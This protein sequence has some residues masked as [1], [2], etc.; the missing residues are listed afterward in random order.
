MQAGGRQAVREEAGSEDE[1]PR[2]E[3]VGTRGMNTQRR[4][5]MCACRLHARRRL[6]HS[7]AAAAVPSSLSARS[8]A[9]EHLDSLTHCSLAVSQS[10]TMHCSIV[11]L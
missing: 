6:H 10:R 3:G 1:E 7:I 4:L 9:V 8:L 2:R 11:A 5:T